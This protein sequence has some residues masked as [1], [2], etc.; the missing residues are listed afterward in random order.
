VTYFTFTPIPLL[1]LQYPCNFES[2]NLRKDE[3]VDCLFPNTVIINDR[4]MS[5]ALSDISKSGCNILLPIQ[6]DQP[7]NVEVNDIVHFRCPML[8]SDPQTEVS[9]VVKRV[10]KNGIKM[11]LGLKFGTIGNDQALRIKK[12]IEQA[13]YLMDA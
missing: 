7:C 2:Y 4:E 13:R 9:G 3:R 5:G 6:D 8:F 10:N 11:E 1:F 12:Y